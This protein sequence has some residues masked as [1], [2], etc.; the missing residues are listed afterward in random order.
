VPASAKGVLS[1]VIWDWNGTLFDDFELTARIAERTFAALGVSGVTGADIR[2]HFRRPFSEFY[3]S[4]LGRP[5]EPAEYAFIRERY[6]LEYQR[7]LGAI[8]LQPDA[9]VALDLV[10]PRAS[11]SLLSMAPDPELQALVDRHGIRARFV[12]VEGSPRTDSD[13]NKAGRMGRHMRALGVDPEGT[14]VIGDTVDD[15]EAAVANGARSVL[16]TTGSTSRRQLEATG[17]PVVDTLEAAARI[18]LE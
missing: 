5:L 10:A 18:A 11:Q 15:H 16:V 8:G 17:A 1:H 12:L 6:E 9:G 4:L 2:A 13:G 14:V 3:G 7:E